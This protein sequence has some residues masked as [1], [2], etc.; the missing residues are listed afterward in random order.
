MFPGIADNEY[1]IEKILF[2]ESC[3]NKKLYLVKWKNYPMEQCTWEPYRNLTNCSEMLNEYNANKSISKNVYE[4]EKFKKLFETLNNHS[5]QELIEHLHIIIEEG[6]SNIEE[7]F[8]KGTVAY[9][10]TVSLNNGD[11]E[12]LKL[13]KHN[14]KVIEVNKR[15]I[16]QLERLDRWQEQM[17][18]VCGF[19]LSV[20]NTVDFEGPPK[21]FIYSDDCVAGKG[22]KIPNDPPVWYVQS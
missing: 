22:V 1:E 17:N 8:V 15:R 2:D 14:L 12:L 19:H 16:K 6:F 21:K 13:L 10:S 11:N 5:E 4:T 18:K 3:G 9:L 20:T 7:Q